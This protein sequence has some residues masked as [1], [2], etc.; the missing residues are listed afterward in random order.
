MPSCCGGQS[1]TEPKNDKSCAYEPNSAIP[2]TSHTPA[3][4]KH[5]PPFLSPAPPPPRKKEASSVHAERRRLPAAGFSFQE[6]RPQDAQDAQVGLQACRLPG[7]E[8]RLRGRAGAQPVGVSG[9]E[10]LER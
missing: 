8:R 7:S 4:P 2:L 10:R 3:V 1:Y 5:F 9:I 6:Q